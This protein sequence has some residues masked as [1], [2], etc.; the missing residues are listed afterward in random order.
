MNYLIAHHVSLWNTF[1]DGVG[2][3]GTCTFGKMSLVFRHALQTPVGEIY[4]LESVRIT[5]QQDWLIYRVCHRR[6]LSSSHFSLGGARGGRGDTSTYLVNCWTG[7]QSLASGKQNWGI[8]F[9]WSSAS[10]MNLNDLSSCREKG[11]RRLENKL[12]CEQDRRSTGTQPPWP[13]SHNCR[14]NLHAEEG[15]Q[16]RLKLFSPS[17]QFQL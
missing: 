17:G 11:E 12:R 3:L 15:L 2:G 13:W 10:L 5:Y 14:L 7:V 16:L 8:A 4:T 6:P 1:Q 9:S